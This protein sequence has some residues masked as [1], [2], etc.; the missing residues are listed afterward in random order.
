MSSK[1]QYIVE[2][3]LHPGQQD[4]FKEQLREIIPYIE[5]LEDGTLIYE[6]YFNEDESKCVVTEQYADSEAMLTHLANVDSRLKQLLTIANITKLEIYGE[7]SAEA[8]AI[9]TSF[10]ATF[11]TRFGGFSRN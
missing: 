6:F 3:S 11:L 10:G 4:L 8:K 1:A 9:A 7:L 5:S 2:F